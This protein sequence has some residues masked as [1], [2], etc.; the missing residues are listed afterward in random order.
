M[1]NRYA[2]PYPEKSTLI[3]LENI[4]IC[5]LNAQKETVF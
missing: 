2:S 3:I 1:F 4:K 5:K